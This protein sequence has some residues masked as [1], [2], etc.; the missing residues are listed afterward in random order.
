M[1]MCMMII[2]LEVYYLL[3]SS[4]YIYSFKKLTIWYTIENSW[5]SCG[6]SIIQ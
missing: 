4:F 3:L 5:N 2:W 6:H 1:C